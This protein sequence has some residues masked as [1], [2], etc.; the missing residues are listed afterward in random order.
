MRVDS[1]T[2]LSW[3]PPV[4]RNRQDFVIPEKPPVRRKPA[5]S[6]S[7]DAGDAPATSSADA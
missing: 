4:G 5:S 2:V 1:D 6:K 3:T 7:I